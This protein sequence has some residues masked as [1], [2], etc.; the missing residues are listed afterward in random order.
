ME[1]KW[2][3]FYT[4][5]RHEKKVLDFLEK[6]LFEVFLPLHKVVRQW[7]DRKKR[8]EVPLF[9]SYIFVRVP[10]HQIPDVLKIPGVSWNI[11][12]G[13]KPAVLREEEFDII[14]R[15]IASG[16]F[17]ET[18]SLER[19]EFKTGDRAKVID[20]PLRGV[21]GRVFKENDGEK[22]EV[23]IDGINQVIRVTMPVELLKKI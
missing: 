10:E 19:D 6:S 8:V 11:K 9:N 21:V 22:L 13:D 2:F 23:L 15:F 17:L 20:G 12:L 7:S 5:S 14:K 1:K 18:S 16:F 3:V 4:K